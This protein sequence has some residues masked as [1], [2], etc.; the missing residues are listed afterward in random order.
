MFNRQQALIIDS[1]ISGHKLHVC[2]TLKPLTTA[3]DF[4][5]THEAR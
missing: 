2:E 4:F 5:T 3:A 1:L